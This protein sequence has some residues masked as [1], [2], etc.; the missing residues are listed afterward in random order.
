[1]VHFV[2]RIEKF[3]RQAWTHLTWYY[4]H[5]FAILAEVGLLIIG[6]PWHVA[7]LHAVFVPAIQ[8]D[9]DYMIRMYNIHPI[10]KIRENGRDLPGHVP[11]GRF[12]PFERIAR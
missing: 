1:M 8:F 7:S 10:R 2:Q 3:W 6:N 4:K 11:A 9:C 5:V 12:R